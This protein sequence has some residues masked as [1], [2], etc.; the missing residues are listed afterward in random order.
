MMA[1]VKSIFF[2]QDCGNDSPRWMGQCSACGAWNTMVEERTT[3]TRHRLG[4]SHKGSFRNGSFRKGS[5]REDGGLS[6]RPLKLNEIESGSET[7]LKTG[8]VE[9]DRVLGGG[10]VKGSAVLVAGDPGIG[11]STLMT[12]LASLLKDQ[13]ILY[14]TG[15]ESLSQVKMR[16]ER[17]GIESENFLLLAE[18]EVESIIRCVQDEEPALLIVDSIQTVF[19]SDLESAPGSVAQVRESA[20]ALIQMAK[21][22]GTA[23]FIV[24]HVTKSGAIAGPRVLEH[25]V[26][27]VLYLE[28][29]QHHAYR[30]LRAVKNRFGSTNEIGVFEMRTMG[31]VPVENPS[32]LFLSDR[33]MLSPGSVV[34]C[35]MEGSRPMLAE[36]QALVTSTSYS[37]PQRT[38][39]G[40]D[41]RRLQMLLAVLEKHLGLP[42]SEC[43]V[44][45]NVTGGLKLSE[46]AADLA[47]AAAVASSYREIPLPSQAI[48]TGEVGLGGEIRAVSQLETRLGEAS[49]LGFTQAFVPKRG[50][51]LETAPK[52]LEC[53]GLSTLDDLVDLL[54]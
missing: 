4:S 18:T 14:V 47:I 30:I 34:V 15:E 37:N 42:L 23:T 13:K 35:S 19:R 48:I 21:S 29:D 6:V 32:E 41:A 10:I 28:G 24:G 26:D 16:A 46:P 50:L 54:F 22:T 45:I 51:N 17:M 44:F 8:N 7:R 39:T 9:M 53:V 43:D 25:M 2:C 5:F 3:S 11:K 36:I 49:R 38:T 27:T 20:A 40:F 31:L 12:E 1:K 33:N 52:K